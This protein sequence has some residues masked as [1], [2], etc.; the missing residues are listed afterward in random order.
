M[1]KRPYG[2]KVDDATWGTYKR[3]R[4]R[5][6]FVIDSGVPPDWWQRIPITTLRVLLL[7]GR[8][9][10]FYKRV[11]GSRFLRHKWLLQ[12]IDIWN[13]DR[14]V[15]LGAFDSKSEAQLAAHALSE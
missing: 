4:G 7:G 2:W 8:F 5:L 13:P 14:S 15:T 3:M 11:T 1:R 12:E 9:I 6:F 10:R